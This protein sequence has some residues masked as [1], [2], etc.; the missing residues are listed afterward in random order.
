MLRGSGS[1]KKRSISQVLA[2]QWGFPWT[3]FWVQ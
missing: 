2:L 3:S 1:A